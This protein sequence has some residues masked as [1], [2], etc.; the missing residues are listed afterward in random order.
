MRDTPSDVAVTGRPAVSRRGI[1]S[2]VGTLP[3]GR[4]RGPYQFG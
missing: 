3:V 1:G 4:D 2:L